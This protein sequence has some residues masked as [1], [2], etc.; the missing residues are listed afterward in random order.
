MTCIFP[1]KCT[2]STK[3]KEALD[4]SGHARFKHMNSITEQNTSLMLS[5]LAYT[6]ASN[7]Q[8]SNDDFT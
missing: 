6:H 7:V 4:F 8:P 5:T 1:I 3:V 2:L